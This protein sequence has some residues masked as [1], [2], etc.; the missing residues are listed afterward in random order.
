[1]ND[2]NWLLKAMVENGTIGRM[3]SGVARA[4]TR[5]KAGRVLKSRKPIS[6]F[7]QKFGNESRPTRAIARSVLESYAGRMGNPKAGR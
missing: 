4:L 2:R 6:K 7:G 3:A 5:S 1:M